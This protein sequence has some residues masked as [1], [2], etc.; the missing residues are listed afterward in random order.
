MTRGGGTARM[1][2]HPIKSVEHFP[3][4]CLWSFAFRD[5]KWAYQ[6]LFGRLL[7]KSTTRN[8]DYAPNIN[9]KKSKRPLNITIYI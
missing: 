9:G 4:Q 3:G 8:K 5:E 2:H 6:W 1:D 7:G